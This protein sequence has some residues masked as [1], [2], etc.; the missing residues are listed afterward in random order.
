[1]VR[2]RE[3][4]LLGRVPPPGEPVNVRRTRETK[5]ED[6]AFLGLHVLVSFAC[7]L[8]ESALPYMGSPTAA[9][10][11]YLYSFNNQNSTNIDRQFFL[12]YA[13]GDKWA[14]RGGS[15]LPLAP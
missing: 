4:A 5:S 1:M 6:P 12:S 2:A 15:A 13:D 11:P 9:G 10:Q 14:D 8:G 7:A 3:S